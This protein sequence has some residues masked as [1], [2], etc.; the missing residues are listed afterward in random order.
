MLNM[1][2][3]NGLVATYNDSASTDAEQSSVYQLVCRAVEKELD[4]KRWLSANVFHFLAHG[5]V[6]FNNVK[7]E[8]NDNDNPCDK[9]LAGLTRLGFKY[10][11][12]TYSHQRNEQRY[13]VKI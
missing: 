12:E 3:I 4:C 13:I 10:R 5:E 6:F 8:S 1:R 7:S 11:F 2:K 9:F